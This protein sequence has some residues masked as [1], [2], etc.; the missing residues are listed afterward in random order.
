MYSRDVLFPL[1]KQIKSN[2]VFNTSD[3]PGPG[4]YNPKPEHFETKTS[5]LMTIG[6]AHT[7]KRL[8][9]E[10]PLPGPGAYQVSDLIL[11]ENKILS[12]QKKSS[13]GKIIFPLS[14]SKRLKTDVN[15]E[16]S[17]IVVTLGLP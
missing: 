6:K 2:N 10:A 16:L 13:Y 1:I 12:K 8:L 11:N 3:V 7:S 15:P 14:S 9:T 4:S 17:K 5:R